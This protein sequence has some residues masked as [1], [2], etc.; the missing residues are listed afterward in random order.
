MSLMDGEPLL[1]A[2]SFK[3]T[4]QLSFQLES[5]NFFLTAYNN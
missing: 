2:R 3:A 1:D 4:L 5:L